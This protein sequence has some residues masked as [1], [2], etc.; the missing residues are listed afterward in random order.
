MN[1]YRTNNTTPTGWQSGW[2]PF[3]Q[4]DGGSL[5]KVELNTQHA[6][7]W[8]S[9]QFVIP[10][11][12]RV[13][14][15]KITQKRSSSGGYLDIWLFPYVYPTTDTW[16]DET[17]DG[18]RGKEYVENVKTVLGYY[19]GETPTNTNTPAVSNNNGAEATLDV[20]TL[21]GMSEFI[22]D[23]TLTLN[24]LLTTT[25]SVTTDSKSEW[26]TYKES[27]GDNR[28]Y[29]TVE[30]YVYDATNGVDYESLSAA[31]TARSKNQADDATD[32][33]TE[34]Q[35]FDDIALSGRV[36]YGDQNGKTLTIMPMVDLTIT[37]STTNA[38]WFLINKKGTG[39]TSS[40]TAGELVIGGDSHT[41]TFDG[42]SKTYT[43]N[44]VKNEDSGKLTLNNVEFKNINLNSTVNLCNVGST[45]VVK[46]NNTTI[47]NCTNPS[48]AYIYNSQ[49]G[50]DYVR[51]MGYF[52]IDA[53]STGTAIYSK[54]RIAL[55]PNNDSNY[56][57]FSASNVITVQWDGTTTLGTSVIIKTLSEYLPI[58]SLTSTDKGL[59]RDASS[60][61]LKL[62]QAYTFAVSDAGAATL[63]LP[64]ATRIPSGVSAYTLTHTSGSDKVTALEVTTTLPA[65]TPVLI[66]AD[67]GSYKF[68]CTSNDATT[69]TT[70]NVTVGALTGQYEELTFTDE[71]KA[72]KY[73]LNKIGENV[74]FYK[75]ATGKKVA[76]NRAYLTAT[77]VP[78]GAG[79][80]S[81]SIEYGD[82]T[83]GIETMK[84]EPLMDNQYY[85]L[86]G[87]RVS[88][89]A[90][91]L[92]IL[93]GKKVIIK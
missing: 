63:V 32:A 87:Q 57:G 91:G 78:D 15:V 92:Y 58:F 54:G 19:P 31:V 17:D 69:A 52:N 1:N 29:I 65:A 62:A 43:A 47:T 51:L 77:N 36:T 5:E 12:A 20:A 28:P 6:R 84:R 81:L 9:E 42:A 55:G 50:N 75:A 64:Y 59:Y 48:T 49:T 3:S 66:N 56:N 7:I 33:N 38:M 26:Y 27:N 24:L 23:G 41:I 71:N 82:G 67:A 14:S 76:A 11:I 72:N 34:L 25:K 10:N 22:S 88:N 60:G 74:G 85:N 35:L 37:Q 4:K 39:S 44:I 53:S 16:D 83:T 21:K 68:V 73:I 8:V 80:R 30:Y 79:A 90:K 93:N 61:D 13:K 89:P 45:G 86:S 18:T 46:L 70:G 2:S 40:G